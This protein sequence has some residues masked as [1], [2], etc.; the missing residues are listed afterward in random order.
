M[1]LPSKAQFRL[2]SII[3]AFMM[4]VGVILA[5]LIPL[6]A[7]FENALQWTYF[8]SVIPRQV[9]WWFWS[10]HQA[11]IWIACLLFCLFVSW[12]RWL[13]LGLIV[14]SIFMGLFSGLYV[15]IPVRDF[16]YYI[17]TVVFWFPLILSF[18]PPCSG[19]FTRKN[20]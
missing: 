15:G 18:Y 17:G 5:E 6:S 11:A 4:T 16:I 14:A 19:Y 13:V 12:S 3:G 20:E 8:E 10:I 9:A 7:G 1:N 2:L